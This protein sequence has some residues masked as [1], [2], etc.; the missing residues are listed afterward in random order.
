MTDEHSGYRNMP[1]YRHLSVNHSRGEYFRA[2]PNGVHV[3]TNGIEV[4][5][6]VLK[7]CIHGTWHR[8]SPEHLDRYCAEVYY[9][10]NEGAQCYSTLHR[11][12]ALIEKC[13]HRT[14]SYREFVGG[15]RAH[16]I[17]PHLCRYLTDA[18]AEPTL[19]QLLRGLSVFDAAEPT[20]RQQAQ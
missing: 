4:T 13:F 10:L 7:R 14:T 12:E 20:E 2:D 17:R 5:W 11:V 16:V 6:A 3:T 15:T 19:E 8:P 9:R 1:G 18:T